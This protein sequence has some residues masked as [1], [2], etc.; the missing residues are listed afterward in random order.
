MKKR[1]IGGWIGD[2]K[3][4]YELLPLAEFEKLAGK[5][6]CAGAWLTATLKNGRRIATDNPI[7]MCNDPGG[8]Q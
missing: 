3:G 1:T 4:D 5:N 7:L 8:R 6:Y 2:N